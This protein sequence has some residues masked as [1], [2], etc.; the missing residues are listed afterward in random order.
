MGRI[1]AIRAATKTYK[2]LL[3]P[4]D[5]MIEVR[6]TSKMINPIS[7]AHPSEPVVAAAPSNQ[8]PTPA[9]TPARTTKPKDTVQ[10]SVASSTLQEVLETP[11]QTAKEARSGDHQAQTLLAKE[12]ASQKS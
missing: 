6:R 4:A 5:G 2:V 1:Y 9:K 10:I 11:V 12:T 3:V 7:R 8:Q